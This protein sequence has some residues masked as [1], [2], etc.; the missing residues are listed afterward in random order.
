YNRV[1]QPQ[2]ISLP[3]TGPLHQ[4]LK[5]FSR[6]EGITINVIVQFLWHKLLQVYSNSRQTIVGTTV[7]GR[8]LPIEG[9]EKSVGLYINTLPLVIDWENDNTTLSQ[10]H[11]IQE[12][13]TALN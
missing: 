12:Q 2:T 6:R 11:K 13:I 9:I 4:A 7:S 3:V 8:D 10:L 5:E 1:E